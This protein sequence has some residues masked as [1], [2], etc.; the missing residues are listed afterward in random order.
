MKNKILK[1]NELVNAP[2]LLT[3]MARLNDKKTFPYDIFIYGGSDYDR[4]RKEHGDPHF[5]FKKSGVFDLKIEIP[6]NWTKNKTLRVIEGDD[7][8]AKKAM[9]ELNKW[10]DGKNHINP[11]IT[12]LEYMI[13]IWNTL[14]VDNT[15]VKQ[16]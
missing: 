6:I 16:I 1:V 4:G 7:K 3:E 11:K 14:N 5:R 2:E 13:L 9:S 10:M 8:N 15:N 12:N